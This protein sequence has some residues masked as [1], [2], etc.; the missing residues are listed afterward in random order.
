MVLRDGELYLFGR[1]KDVIIVNGRNLAPQD[2]E[3]ALD[4][5]E[6]VRPG[7]YAAI[8]TQREAGET[9]TVLVESRLRDDAERERLRREIRAAVHGRIGLDCAVVLLAAGALP[10]TSS[11]KIGRA[12]ARELFETD[13][14]APPKSVNAFRMAGEL[15]KSY[16]AHRRA[17]RGEA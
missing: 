16:R 6:G 17:G 9:L 1:G 14:L 15:F 4:E 13:R 12:R 10:R 3:R 11:G 5:I 7:C 2:V 8:G